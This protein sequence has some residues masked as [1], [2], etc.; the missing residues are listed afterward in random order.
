M[1]VG[2]AFVYL[3]MHKLCFLSCAILPFTILFIPIVDFY[4]KKQ[5][6]IVTQALWLKVLRA[7]RHNRSVTGYLIQ[8]V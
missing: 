6:N 7:K 4:A 3:K 5:H 8:V 2:K 1:W